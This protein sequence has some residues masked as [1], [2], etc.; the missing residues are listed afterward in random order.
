MNPKVDFFFDKAT[1]WYDEQR[2]LRSIVLDCQLK[3]ELKW[4]VPCYTYQDKNIILIHSFKEYCA[5]LFVKGALLKDPKGILIQQTENVQSARQVRFTSVADIEAVQQT[6]KQYIFEAVEVEESGAKVALKKTKDYA[7]PEEFQ[8]Q[9][10]ANA[11]L[12]E[13]FAALT[14]GRQRAYLFYFGQAKQS[15]T[16]VSRVEKCIPQIMEGKGL[17]D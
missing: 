14:P 10:D 9:L 3:E 7:I 5:V 6:L 16:R 15:K 17:D 1:K 8:E 4:G 2:L 13:A 11:A 12:K